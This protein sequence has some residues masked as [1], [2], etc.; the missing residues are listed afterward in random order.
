MSE[1][2]L[3]EPT[4]KT[5]PASGRY[6]SLAQSSSG[7]LLLYAQNVVSDVGG[8]PLATEGVGVVVA[9]RLSATGDPVGEPFDVAPRGRPLDATFDGTDYIVSWRVVG[10]SLQGSVFYQRISA[11]GQLIGVPTL[12]VEGGTPVV[13]MS[14][15]STGETLVVVC[16]NVVPGPGCQAKLL[17]GNSL[18]DA[19]TLPFQ[20]DTRLAYSQGVWLA[21]ERQLEGGTR[22]VQLDG[23]GELIDG[24]DFTLAESTANGSISATA[25][26]TGF[27]V[28]WK[29]AATQSIRMATIGFD[30]NSSSAALSYTAQG[31]DSLDFQGIQSTAGGLLVFA[32]R[33]WDSLCDLPTCAPSS[34][35]VI[36]E[37]DDDLALL[38]TA[39]IPGEAGTIASARGYFVLADR[40]MTGFQ[41]SDELALSDPLVI[42]TKSARMYPPLSAPG[43]D[44]WLVAWTEDF[45]SVEHHRSFGVRAA[46]LSSDGAANADPVLLREAMELRALR[47]GPGGWMMAVKQ[48]TYPSDP[49][50]GALLFLPHENPLAAA[51]EVGSWRGHV[52]LASSRSGWLLAQASANQLSVRRKGE[53]GSWEDPTIIATLPVGLPGGPELTGVMDATFDGQ[54]YVVTWQELNRVLSVRIPVEGEVGVPESRI[55]LSIL[56]DRQLYAVDA[57]FQGDGWW[58]LASHNGGSTLVTDGD[59]VS[60]ESYSAGSISIVDGH[61]LGARSATAGE[62]KFAIVLAAAGEQPTVAD[63]GEDLIA[64]DISE[65][66]GNRALVA[67][68]KRTGTWGE[69]ITRV[70]TSVVQIEGGEDGGEGGEGGQGAAEGG[71]AGKDGAGAEGGQARGGAAADQ[72][73]AAAIAPAGAGG[74]STAN[75]DDD[76]N[77]C[78]CRLSGG[79]TS[80]SPLLLLLAAGLA[81]RRA[82]RRALISR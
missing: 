28:A 78:G 35:P 76:D 71:D 80:S 32:N 77:G 74:E 73:G 55:L 23:D 79:S 27:A 45:P 38:G 56:D 72:G 37:L 17:V 6:L 82:R 36:A 13:S 8:G 30:A 43:P 49:D 44:G 2:R 34:E 9:Q 7:M 75:D 40:I 16:P 20:R 48:P 53:N 12:L 81:V 61:L 22:F 31:E 58:L 42:A 63:L 50:K 47:D 15:G 54:D 24:T 21:W 10:E 46:L 70:A 14:G 26:P 18:T 1:V 60:D 19:A 67:G 51:A 4:P 5:M 39:H 68:L 65:P 33:H 25:L 52:E 11:S 3:V 41:V 62:G 29:Q 66:L 64:L 57:A 59:G 69:R